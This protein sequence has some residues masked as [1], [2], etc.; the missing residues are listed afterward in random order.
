MTGL[1]RTS[2]TTSKKVECAASAL[3]QQG[4]YGI[5]TQLIQVYGISRSSVYT[6]GATAQEVQDFKTTTARP[7]DCIDV[8]LSGIAART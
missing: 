5:K 6:A 8:K 2:L 7:P 1:Y 3:A 4:E